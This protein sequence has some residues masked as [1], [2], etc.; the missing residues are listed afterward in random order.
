MK[1]SP[2]A[3]HFPCMPAGVSEISIAAML[4]FGGV[5]VEVYKTVGTHATEV[6]ELPIRLG[7]EIR[8]GV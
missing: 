6:A 1:A 5:G 2:A 7:I 3:V 8:P 4:V